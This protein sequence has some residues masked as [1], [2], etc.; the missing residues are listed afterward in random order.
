[1]DEPTL[2][3]I[4]EEFRSV[5]DVLETAKK[6]NLDNVIVLS[7]KPNGNILF[8]VNGDMTMAQTN[9]LLDRFKAMILGTLDGQKVSK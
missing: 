3:R 4:P 9:W 7:E 2:L 1:M 5:D 8:L 6:L